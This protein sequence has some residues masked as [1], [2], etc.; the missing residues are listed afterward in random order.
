MTGQDDDIECLVV[1]R[2]LAES[3]YFSLD[4]AME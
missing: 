3:Q 4:S 1:G 2:G